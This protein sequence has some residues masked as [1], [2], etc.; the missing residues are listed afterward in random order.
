MMS[1]W[2]DRASPARLRAS[3]ATAV[4]VVMLGLIT[5]GHFAA[6][7]DPLHYWIITESVAFDRDFDV[8]NNY[9]EPANIIQTAPEQHAVPG[10]NG[11]LRPIH[12][13]GLP[14][15]AAPFFAAIYKLA[16]WSDRLPPALR[17]RAKLDRFM[18]LR[19]LL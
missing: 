15:A 4:T 19:Q 14:I 13:I 5:H 6:G 10:R 12:D 18:V 16:E 11:V 9:F 1:R 3:L 7:G 8:R 2:I 17:A